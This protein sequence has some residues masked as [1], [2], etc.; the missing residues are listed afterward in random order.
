M[1]APQLP[2]NPR[3]KWQGEAC[4]APTA[5]AKRCGSLKR[6]AFG[7]GG[8]DS[9]RML[10]GCKGEEPSP[11][12]RLEAATQT[13]HTPTGLAVESTQTPAWHTEG[14]STP[15]L[16]LACGQGLVRSDAVRRYLRRDEYALKGTLQTASLPP[17]RDSLSR[18]GESSWPGGRKGL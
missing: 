4:L 16:I 7:D 9:S 18:Q 3:Q 14:E 15:V 6:A 11:R 2:P 12:L 8:P 17:P 5:H 1:G 13:L 10:E